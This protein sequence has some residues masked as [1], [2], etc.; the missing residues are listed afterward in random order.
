VALSARWKG[1]AIYYNLVTNTRIAPKKGVELPEPQRGVRADRWRLL[2]AVVAVADQ[3]RVTGT[4]A[5][6][7]SR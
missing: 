4:F 1:Q 2:G 6:T 7:F 5:G 3:Y